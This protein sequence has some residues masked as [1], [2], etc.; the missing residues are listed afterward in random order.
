[1]NV[2]AMRA[3]ALELMGRLEVEPSHVRHVTAL[4]LSLFDQ[5]RGLHQLAERERLILEAA[6]S[7]HDIGWSVAKDG[8]G[9]HKESARLI[10]EARWREW[11]AK[12]VELVACVARYHRKAEPSL[13][14]EEFAALSGADQR[15]VTALAALL[16]IADAL[17][18]SHTQRVE[19]VRATW[20][21]TEL[22]LLLTSRRPLHAEEAAVRKKGALAE[23][24][25]GRT[26]MLDRARRPSTVEF[27][28]EA[29][30][31]S[32]RTEG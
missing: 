16:R 3:E 22:H 19:D 7:L 30:G 28:G 8:K 2:E 31:T 5:M 27:V 25:W 32:P 20:T 14:H 9:H 18:R 26:L 10:R 1:M 23:R 15:M 11:G 12:D 13:E 24:V 6:A 29:A 21:D 17:D 4:A